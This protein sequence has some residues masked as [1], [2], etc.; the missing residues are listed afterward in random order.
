MSLT[1]EVDCRAFTPGIGIGE[2]HV[3]KSRRS[4][5]SF[6]AAPDIDWEDEDAYRLFF[7]Y[8]LGWVDSS[9]ARRCLARSVEQRAVTL[10]TPSGVR[11]LV[12][13]NGS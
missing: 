12:A 13:A 10:S 9:I 11:I 6:C 3:R 2:I 4:G 8:A 7:D 5:I 1:S